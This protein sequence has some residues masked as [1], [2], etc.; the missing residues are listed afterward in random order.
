M[1]CK[2]VPPQ[3]PGAPVLRPITLTPVPIE[4]GVIELRM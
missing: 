2:A 3:M 1:T 4:I